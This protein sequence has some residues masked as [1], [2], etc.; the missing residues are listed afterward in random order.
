VSRIA[1]PREFIVP[2]AALSLDQLSVFVAIVEEGSFSGAARRLERTQP[3]ISYSIAALERA[4]G[5]RLFD[6]SGARATLTSVGRTLVFNARAV[7]KSVNRFYVAAAELRGETEAALSIVA[8]PRFP[9]E[10]LLNSLSA[11]RRDHPRLELALRVGA[12]TDGVV[13]GALCIVEQSAVPSSFAVEKVGSVRLLPVAAVHHP[14]ASKP[15]SSIDAERL[16]RKAACALYYGLSDAEGS[17]ET[18]CLDTLRHLVLSGLGWAQLPDWLIQ[19]DLA[20]GRLTRLAMVGDGGALEFCVAYL[21]GQEPGP[22]GRA[23]VDALCG[24]PPPSGAQRVA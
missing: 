21:P 3:A 12:P 20:E 6:R 14:L 16:T 5:L 18:P 4:L 15:L 17:I 13:D 11:V 22:A 23:F 10:T 8:D 1:A 9:R 19:A 7:M 2:A 24:D